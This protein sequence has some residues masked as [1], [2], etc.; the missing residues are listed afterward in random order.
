MQFRIKN[1]RPRRFDF[2]GEIGGQTEGGKLL[3]KFFFDRI[4][5]GN[6]DLTKMSHLY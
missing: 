5:G 3:E 1:G 6:T 4:I 2:R